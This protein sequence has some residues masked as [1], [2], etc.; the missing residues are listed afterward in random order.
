M[1]VPSSDSTISSYTTTDKQAPITVLE[2]YMDSQTPYPKD[3][4]LIM[5]LVASINKKKRKENTKKEREKKRERKKS[6]Y[7]LVVA[8]HP[9]PNVQCL[10]TRLLTIRTLSIQAGQ[11]QMR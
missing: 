8:L 10:Q 2:D 4:G 3:S 1:H 7:L 5:V 11:R 6:P 9:T